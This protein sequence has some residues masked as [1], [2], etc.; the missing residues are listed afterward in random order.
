LATG[1]AETCEAYEPTVTGTPDWRTVGGDPAGTGVVPETGAPEPPL[2]LDWTFTLGGHTGAARPVATADRVYAHE[3][4]S[5]LYAVDAATGE[6]VW[7]KAVDNPRGSVAIGDDVVVVLTG[8]AVLGLDPET[9]ATRWTTSE[10]HAGLFQGSPVIVGET[11]YVPTALSLLALDLTDGTVRWTH[12]TG[13]ETVATPAIVGD[14][15]YYGDQD[16]YIYAVDAATGEERWRVKTNA[17]VNCNVVVADGTVFAGSDDGGFHALDAETGDR[18]WT[19]DL[20]SAPEVIASD[21]AHAYV[22]AGSTVHAIEAATGEPCWSTG[23]RDSYAPGL[24]V[25]GGRVYAPLPKTSGGDEG[26][27][28]VLA[29]ATGEVLAR[30]NGEFE[31]AYARFSQGPAVVDGAV[32]ASGVDEDGIGLAR[33][34]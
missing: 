32:Y 22:A 4:D 28:G 11:A 14:T 21:G 7:A 13:E 5:M 6:E 24:A 34:S 8:S 17:H 33:F 9:G 10:S 3:L 27:P 15:V 30:A 25:G 19:Y 2:S 1:R 31:S 18:H 23:Y 20:E 12:T 16:T 29:A 26:L